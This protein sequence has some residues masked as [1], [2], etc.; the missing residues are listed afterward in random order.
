MAASGGA[1]KNGKWSAV[2]G[3]KQKL[4]A[5]QWRS[6]AINTLLDGRTVNATTSSGQS[7]S[8]K[9]VDGG[10]RVGNQFYQAWSSVGVGQVVEQLDIVKVDYNGS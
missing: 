5:K 4:S 8:I 9:P 6:V 7:V 10:L 2:A 1:W 3:A